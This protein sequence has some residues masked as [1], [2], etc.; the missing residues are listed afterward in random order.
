MFKR[1]YS[2]I[3][4]ILIAAGML[5]ACSE[6]ETGIQTSET[7]AVVTESAKILP[8][9]PAT[10]FNGEECRILVPEPGGGDWE[11]WGSRD[12]I[13]EEQTGE[14]INDAVY[15]RNLHVEDTY[16]V[17]IKGI[18]Q[19]GL[20][21]ATSRMVLAGTDD[22]H[23]VTDYIKSM[24]SSITSG[25]LANLNT[26]EHMDLSQPWYDQQCVTENSIMGKTYFITGDM[27]L[28]DDDATAA[29][30]FNK[31][32]LA[33][34]NLAN[35]YDYVHKNEWTYENFA[36]MWLD[37]GSDINGDGKIDVDDQFGLI[38]QNDATIAF[39]HALGARIATLDAEGVPEYTLG[40]EASLNAFEAIAKYLY[41]TDLVINC[42]DYSST[43]T[44]IYHMLQDPIF[45]ENRAL[46]N[47]VRMRVVENYRNMEA[48]FGIIPMP[49][50][51]AG[52]ESYY[53]TVN[54][55]TCNT[56]EIP[57]SAGIDPGFSGFII[58]AMSAESTYT[59]KEAYYEINLG[60]KIT[61]DEESKEMLDIIFSTRVYDT[62]EI[63]NWGGVSDAVRNIMQQ[64]RDTFASLVSQYE[65]SVAKNLEKFVSNWEE[66][67]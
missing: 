65:K 55:N 28:I 37:V 60:T 56:I 44:N 53:H 13:A 34:Y 25:Y 14:T 9:L 23:I 15:S 54:S 51:D 36:S 47:W 10:D 50:L 19:S 7:E 8:D 57:N 1:I 52:Q 42:H 16:K 21:A 22:Y 63:Y 5:A 3:V 6:A 2:L 66:L 33:D 35:P 59:L 61:R 49:K 32:L 30:L 27:I 40:S 12:M 11:D 29:L 43:Y 26:V 45:T 39:F 31:K 58:E 64:K 67:E 38:W 62:G 4:C 20:A 18:M 17:Q 48:D 41:N 46:F 24:I